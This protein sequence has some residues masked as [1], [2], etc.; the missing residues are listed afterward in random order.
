MMY[1]SIS[2]YEGHESTIKYIEK[3]YN[4]QMMKKASKMT[5]VNANESLM[6]TQMAQIDTKL[7]EN[8]RQ[9]KKS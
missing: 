2:N 9:V 3:K 7:I 5:G 4:N 8:H 1:C 6:E